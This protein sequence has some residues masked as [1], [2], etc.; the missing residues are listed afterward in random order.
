MFKA[1]LHCHTTYSKCSTMSPEELVR[2]A[3]SK[4][5]G[6]LGV[7]DHDNIR[8]AEAVKKAAKGKILVL[9]GEEISTNKGH[10]IVFFSDGKFSKDI[11]EVCDRAKDIGAFVVAPHPFDIARLTGIG[12]T[13]GKIRVDA[14]EIFNSRVIFN[15]FNIKAEDFAM[16][17][18]LPMIVGSDAHS[19]QEVGLALNIFN[20]SK[21]ADSII[22]SIRKGKVTFV[23]NS[24]GIKGHVAT[25]KAKAKRKIFGVGDGV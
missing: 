7:V 16:G 14:V 10:L 4:E 24:S 20:C 1:D 12:R 2:A 21:D 6:V 25:L 15:R 19:P 18:K 13:L 23:K 9:P 5:I 11:H 22:E 8:G 3:V 17:H